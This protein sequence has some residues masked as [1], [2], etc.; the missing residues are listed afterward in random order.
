M[1]IQTVLDSQQADRVYVNPPAYGKGHVG[2]EGTGIGDAH[3]D[4]PAVLAPQPPAEAGG[5][6]NEIHAGQAQLTLSTIPISKAP[7][8]ATSRVF[9]RASLQAAKWRVLTAK[10]AL[11]WCLWL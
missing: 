6:A 1:S 5:R 3:H 7:N 11:S 10:A 2:Q 9:Q 4:L 8:P